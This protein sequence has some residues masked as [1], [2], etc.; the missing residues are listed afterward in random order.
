MSE[1]PA[2]LGSLL[3]AAS[4]PS[5][6]DEPDHIAGGF[7]HHLIPVSWVDHVDEHVHLNV[8]KDDAKARWT[9]KPH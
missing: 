2:L 8:T 9:D 5:I 1:L 6:Q 4:A 7:K 3:V